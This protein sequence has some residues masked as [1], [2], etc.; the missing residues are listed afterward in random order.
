MLDTPQRQAD[1]TANPSWIQ[2]RRNRLTA[3]RFASACGVAG[4]K[5][6]QV[7]L[8]AN[9]TSSS[10]PEAS[11]AR[12]LQFGVIH[13]DEA[14][15]AYVEFKRA[16]AE[17]TGRADAF[18]VREV[19]MCIMPE[20]PWL[21]GSP[22][23]LCFEGG[24]P[25]GLLEVKTSTRWRNFSKFEMPVDWWYQI[26]GSMRVASAAL[27][28]A[29]CWCDVFLWTPEGYACTRF[30]FDADLWE[31]KM[32]PRLRS[33]YFSRL[34][35]KLVEKE[36]TQQQLADRES[37]ARPYSVLAAVGTTEHTVRPRCRY[38]G[39]CFRWN[40]DHLRTYAHPWDA[41]WAQDGELYLEWNQE[42]SQEASA[43]KR[44]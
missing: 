41:D 39:D 19:G 12:A 18:E 32:F 26:Q 44:W 35:P 42:Q 25:V 6:S 7:T 14:R 27:G 16:E 37:V 30:D 38:G 13:E 20:E 11:K 17:Q 28:V 9:L 40:P 3:S 36:A 10:L 31:R 5:L 15:Q 2:A 23:G 4:S 22:D 24:E 1:L 8:I 21:A 33:F 29:I 34:L 43:P